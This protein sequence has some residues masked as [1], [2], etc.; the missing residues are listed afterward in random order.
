MVTIFVDATILCLGLSFLGSLVIQL[1]SV[2]RLV[3][4][5]ATTKKARVFLS[6]T[7]SLL[8]VIYMHEVVAMLSNYWGYPAFKMT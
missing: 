1:L 5:L 4:F 6:L 8:S 7:A 3:R 2:F